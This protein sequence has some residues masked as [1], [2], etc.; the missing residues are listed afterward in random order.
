MTRPMPD[1]EL[2][3][4]REIARNSSHVAMVRLAQPAL[5]RL[6]AEIDRLRTAAE[7]DGWDA[8][9]QQLEGQQP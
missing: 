4:W 1:R 9:H 3:G 5:R 6:V 2:D 7:P 8:L